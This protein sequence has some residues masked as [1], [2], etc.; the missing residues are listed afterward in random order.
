MNNWLRA[1]SA[2]ALAF[3]LQSTVPTRISCDTNPLCIIHKQRPLFLK[4]Q[5]PVKHGDQRWKR[6]VSWLRDSGEGRWSWRGRISRRWANGSRKERNIV[7]LD[8]SEGL[9][10]RWSAE[11]L[12]RVSLKW[13]LASSW[14]PIW[15]S[16]SPGPPSCSF[17]LRF[18]S[19]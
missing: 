5:T 15:F 11:T 10:G 14:D 17:F 1:S 19:N 9:G 2:L 16:P 8:P 18:R 7:F 6:E 12:N 13:K 3:T 4:R